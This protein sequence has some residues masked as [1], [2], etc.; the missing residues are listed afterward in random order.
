MTQ[1]DLASQWNKLWGALGSSQFLGILSFIAFLIAVV[2]IVKFFVDKQRGRGGDN[3]KLIWTAVVCMVLA[4]P[5]TIIPIAL[6][7]VDWVLNIFLGALS[8]L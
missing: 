4:A 5:G 2:A 3:Q 8:S 6:K 1:I 7:I